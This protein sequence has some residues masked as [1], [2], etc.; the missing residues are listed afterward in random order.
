M[1]TA[2]S[3]RQ[4]T[5]A[6]RPAKL[7]VGA[8]GQAAESVS[9]RLEALSSRMNCS[10]GGH[11]PV[12]RTRMR[13]ANAGRVVDW[14]IPT[15]RTNTDLPF[16]AVDELRF[17]SWHEPRSLGFACVQDGRVADEL[18]LSGR[19]NRATPLS[20]HRRA[21]AA[22]HPEPRHACRHR[23]R[24][25]RRHHEPSRWPASHRCHRDHD[26]LERRPRRAAAGVAAHAG[27]RRRAGLRGG[28]P[29]AR[30]STWRGGATKCASPMW[31]P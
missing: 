25:A 18:T 20:T 30:A 7:E 12:R 9:D 3:S 21:Y 14:S 1:P 11:V 13:R 31:L 27:P 23:R 16:R 15:T 22:A 10:A 28:A 24:C 29:G 2:P 6:E 17:P 4:T 5:L 19:A 26:L 8:R